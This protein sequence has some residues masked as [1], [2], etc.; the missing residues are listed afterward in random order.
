MESNAFI[1]LTSTVA[2]KTTSYGLI[3][4]QVFNEHHALS[5]VDRWTEEKG[6]P[7]DFE[8]TSVSL[9]DASNFD[10]PDYSYEID[11]REYRIYR[12]SYREQNKLLEQQNRDR[13]L[14]TPPPKCTCGGSATEVKAVRTEQYFNDVVNVE[15]CFFRCN[16]CHN[17]F[18]TPR[19][20]RLHMRA[21]K[22][23]VRKKHNG[24]LPPAGQ[25]QNQQPQKSRS[26]R[27]KLMHARGP[28]LTNPTALSERD[29]V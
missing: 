12:S 19:F 27:L 5:I 1:T 18:M 11:G 21:I 10:R 2:E 13:I 3:I 4:R 25:A 6:I 17:E 28:R 15:T 20:R 7:Q 16:S 29:R 9:R 24:V 8:I 23:E 22:A 14:N 26:V